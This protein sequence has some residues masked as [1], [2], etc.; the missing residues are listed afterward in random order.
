MIKRPED[1]AP[2]APEPDDTPDKEDE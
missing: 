2:D 1:D